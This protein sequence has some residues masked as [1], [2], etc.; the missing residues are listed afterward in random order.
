MTSIIHDFDVIRTRRP[1]A[2][3]AEE[4]PHPTALAALIAECDRAWTAQTKATGEAEAALWPWRAANPHLDEKTD[5]PAPIAALQ[6][7]AEALLEPAAALLDRV[8]NWIPDSVADAVRLLELEAECI[9]TVDSVLAG[10]RIIAGAG[11]PVAPA[12]VTGDRQ[13]L[14]LFREWMSAKC[15]AASI[16]DTADDDEDFDAASKEV[17]RFEDAIAETPAEGLLGLAVKVF[18]LYGAGHNVL[19]K[20]RP[21]ADPCALYPPTDRD[22]CL[23]PGM[24]LSAVRDIARLVPALARLCAPALAEE[25]NR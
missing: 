22:D 5:L 23:A 14:G 9:E 25:A 7:K 8:K 1:S 11:E 18:F 24:S 21:G 13:I 16:P 10:L 2:E 12:P 20:G 6:E 15:H 19:P 17:D 4:T 3:L